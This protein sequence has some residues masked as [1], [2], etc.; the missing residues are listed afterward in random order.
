[1]RHERWLGRLLRIKSELDKQPA[2]IVAVENGDDIG[3]IPQLVLSP[4]DRSKDVRT[5]VRGLIDADPAIHVDDSRRAGNMLVISPIALT[6]DDIPF[7]ARGLSEQ[8]SQ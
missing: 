8:F 3:A 6:D 4:R 7:L 1:T 5:I 2:I